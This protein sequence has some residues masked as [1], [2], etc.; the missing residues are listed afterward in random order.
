[1]FRTQNR[2]PLIL[3]LV[4]IATITRI[5]FFSHF[6]NFSP[7][8]AIALF[9]GAYFRRTIA[10]FV[11]LSSVWIG[12]VL[13]DHLLMGH[14]ILFYAGC[15]WQYTSYLFITMIGALLIHRVK[16]LYVI[17]ASFSA[18]VSFFVISN[19]G[20][21]YSS[22][23][24][25]PTFQGLISCYVAAIPFFKNTVMS[26]G[27]FAFVLFGSFEW[28]FQKNKKQFTTVFPS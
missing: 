27:L 25:P 20:V 28:L 1:M 18:S 15:Y 19:F 3:S 7:V 6:A 12:D 2:M 4:L 24:Y 11:A 22:L 13:I 17:F 14:W 9:C 5:G 8:N 21:W 26:D 10:F 16:P 23:L